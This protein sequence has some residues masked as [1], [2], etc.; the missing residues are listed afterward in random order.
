[1]GI[2]HLYGKG[3]KHSHHYV[4]VDLYTYSFTLGALLMLEIFIKGDDLFDE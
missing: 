1:M 4:D 3:N 2:L